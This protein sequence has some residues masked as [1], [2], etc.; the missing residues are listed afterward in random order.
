VKPGKCM[1]CTHFSRVDG[2]PHWWGWC[3]LR[4][5][6]ALTYEAGCRRWLPSEE[7]IASWRRWG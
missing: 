7:A 6:R 4:M 1:E 5:M 2:W 3:L